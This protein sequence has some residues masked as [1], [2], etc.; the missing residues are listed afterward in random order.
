V[1]A[2]QV[3]GP[4]QPERRTDERVRGVLVG[5]IKR[6]GGQVTQLGG[7]VDPA[8]LSLGDLA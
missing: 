5:G 3:P 4:P 8:T 7:P 1:D 2:A 6:P